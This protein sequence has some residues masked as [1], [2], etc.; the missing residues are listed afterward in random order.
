MNTDILMI[1]LKISLVIFM[2]GNLLEKG[3]RQ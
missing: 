3:D 1:P 2:A